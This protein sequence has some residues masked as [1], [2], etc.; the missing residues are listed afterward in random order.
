MSRL[1]A[2]HGAVQRF[3]DLLSPPTGEVAQ[4][5]YDF[6]PAITVTILIGLVRTSAGQSLQRLQSRRLRSTCG[7][8]LSRSRVM[9]RADLGYRTPIVHVLGILS[10]QSRECGNQQHTF[11]KD[12]K[13]ARDV[14]TNVRSTLTTLKAQR[15]VFD[16]FQEIAQEASRAIASNPASD[17]SDQSH[18]AISRIHAVLGRTRGCKWR[19][20][21]PGKRCPCPQT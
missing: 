4:K 15:L 14:I 8:T 19:P 12:P 3:L 20:W 5:G 9:Y 7:G 18:T 11:N 17:F 13:S 2:L 6:Q 16:V 21:V 1:D 10:E